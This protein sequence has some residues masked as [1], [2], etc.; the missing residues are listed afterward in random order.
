M[1]LRLIILICGA[2]ALTPA[3]ADDA[4]N[5]MASILASLNHFPTDADKQKLTAIVEDAGS[6]EIDKQLA[7]IIAGIAHQASAADKEKL[8]AILAEDAASDESKLIAKAILGTMHRPTAEHLKS[9]H[10]LIAGG[11]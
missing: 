2:M 9:L 11:S 1:K 3:L 5:T 10:Q 6:S 4:I 8:N 7:E